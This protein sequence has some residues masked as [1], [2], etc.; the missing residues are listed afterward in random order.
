MRNPFVP[1][2]DSLER[3]I[4][5][6]ST[7]E[8]HVE[9]FREA[10]TD[11]PAERR[12]RLVA[13]FLALREHLGT[14]WLARL[15]KARSGM[16]GFLTN[17]APWVFEWMAGLAAD[18]ERCAGLDG[19]DRVR[20]SLRDLARQHAAFEQVR[21]AARYLRAGCTVVLEPAVGRRAADILVRTPFELYIELQHLTQGTAERATGERY[22]AL[23]DLTLLT[24][25]G[26]GCVGRAIVTPHTDQAAIV[27][28][29]REAYIK[30]AAA[31]EL[32]VVERPD[33]YRFV[34]FPEHRRGELP[35]DAQD[36]PFEATLVGWDNLRRAGDR[37]RAKRAQLPPDRPGMVVL[38]ASVFDLGRAV[39]EHPA[40]LQAALADA[41]GNS[42]SVI[43]VGVVHR[44]MGPREPMF[45]VRADT[46]R[47]LRADHDIIGEAGLFI[48][49]PVARWP[50]L[51]THVEPLAR[52]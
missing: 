33:E 5:D 28:R 26:I 11:I 8:Y 32:V 27:Q 18:L 2:G 48:A 23:A 1:P 9:A 42:T 13:G 37:V 46:I 14:D 44:W 25:P 47:Y 41:A 31:Q 20:P 51:P 49:N 43:G 39:V 50:L 35:A 15:V 3:W 7:W 34:I 45:D 10:A 52:A 17:R 16:V 24:P 19:F 22:R 21:L 30:A 36:T 38:I 4:A 40:E 12:E 29:V 6:M